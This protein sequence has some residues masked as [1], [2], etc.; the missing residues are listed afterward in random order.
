MKKVV[1][2]QAKVAWRDLHVK[3]VPTDSYLSV[4]LYE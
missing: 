2:E 3:S 4:L 1:R